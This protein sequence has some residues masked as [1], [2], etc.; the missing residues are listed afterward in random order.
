MRTEFLK[1]RRTVLRSAIGAVA[2]VLLLSACGSGPATPPAESSRAE[3]ATSEVANP[4]ADLDPC[5]LLTEDE[6]ASFGLKK[7]AERRDVAGSPGC[8]WT[9]EE[10][11][12][13]V[14]VHPDRSLDQL[15]VEGDQ[16]EETTLAGRQAKMVKPA[17]GEGKC[18]LLV[19]ISDSTAAGISANMD[20]NN[21]D[22]ACQVVN[23]VAPRVE[24]K[25][26]KN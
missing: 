3:P 9:L 18:E 13:A 19:E 24:A 16:V 2:G 1:L 25:L 12:I 26:P 7:A 17:E 5:Q 20:D 8:R 6:V 11:L 4:V 15:N 23:Q 21:N 22:A 14:A 10:G